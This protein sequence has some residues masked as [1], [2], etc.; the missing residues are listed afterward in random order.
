MCN[1]WLNLN[2]LA[3][4]VR[5]S[6]AYHIEIFHVQH[7]AIVPWSLS[8][9]FFAHALSAAGDARL[10]RDEFNKEKAVRTVA[11]GEGG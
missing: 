4:V 6:L 7:D 8:N 9:A 2:R 10:H 3:D 5:D 1:Q 11:M